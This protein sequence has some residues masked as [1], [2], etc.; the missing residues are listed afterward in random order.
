[1][2][3]QSTKRTHNF[4]YFIWKLFFKDTEFNE[5]YLLKN[6]DLTELFN[7]KR[8]LTFE[9]DKFKIKALKIIK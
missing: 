6:I 9:D 8:A 7:F 5:P 3:E 1:M 4:F 2:Y